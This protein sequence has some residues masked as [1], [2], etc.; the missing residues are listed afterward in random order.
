MLDHMDGIMQALAKKKT[1]WKEHLYITVRVAQ[2][3]L[4]KYYVEVTPMTGLILI[5]ADNLDPFCKLRVFRKWEK[6]MY[7]NPDNNITNTT[8]SQE[9]FLKHIENE[10]CAKHRRL[11]IN[12]SEMVTSN[13]HFPTGMTF[14]SG[15]SSFYQ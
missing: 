2:H 9:I 3:K 10:C 15:Q 11:S 5:S 12:Q 8:Q 7:I 14:G 6:G 4:F 1:Q 13:N